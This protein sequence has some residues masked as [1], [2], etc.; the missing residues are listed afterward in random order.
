MKK[1]YRNISTCQINLNQCR[2]QF[3]HIGN[4]F[5]TIV[6]NLIVYNIGNIVIQYIRDELKSD[7][8]IQIKHNS[9]PNTSL[10]NVVFTFNISAIC[11]T[12]ALPIELPN[13]TIKWNVYKIT[14]NNTKYGNSHTG[15][16]KHSQCCVYFQRFGDLC[17]AIYSNTI[18]YISKQKKWI[19]LENLKWERK[20]IHSQQKRISF[21][22]LFNLN[23]SAIL[24]TPT[25]PIALPNIKTWDFSKKK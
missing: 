13:R 19:P 18:I 17:S 22:V 8:K 7:W 6:T 14:C 2:I 12:P 24:E 1:K 23:A 10:V 15:E 11:F 16:I 20:T 3:Q 25:S 21:N 5:D 9:L 4:N